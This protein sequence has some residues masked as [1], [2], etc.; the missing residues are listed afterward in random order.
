MKLL[1]VSKDYRNNIVDG[2]SIVI[3]RNLELLKEILGAANVDEFYIN[4][5]I[6]NIKKAIKMLTLSSVGYEK[7][8]LHRLITEIKKNQYDFIFV[9]NSLLGIYVKKIKK[10]FPQI[11][12][13]S[14]FH[15]IEL[16]YFKE[17]VKVDGLINVI[18][19]PYAYHN[20]KLTI[21]YSNLVIVLNNRDNKFLKSIYKKD[22]NLILPLTLK[23]KFNNKIIN[24]LQS[25]CNNDLTYIFVGSNF[26][27]NI[28]GITWFIENVSKNISGKLQ[29]IGSGMEILKEKYGHYQNIEILGFVDDLSYYYINADFVII[30]IFS[31]SGM[32]TKTTEALMYGKTIFGTTEAFEGFEL[33][34]DKVGALCNSK[35]EFI[36]SINDYIN[37]PR[38]K[39]NQYSRDIFLKKYSNS[40]VKQNLENLLINS[41]KWS[42]RFWNESNFVKCEKK[43][44]Y[45]EKRVVSWDI[46]F[47]YYIYLTKRMGANN[48]EKSL[49]IME[50]FNE[51]RDCCSWY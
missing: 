34:Y 24:N 48:V 41:L 15:N 50:G 29:I 32:K 40:A 33:D 12:I 20:E 42:V 45:S 49:L 30:P 31:G 8:V 38:S 6:L 25:N 4:T 35:E 16:N 19:L 14:F 39:F 47:D 7:K 37:G 51:N 46:R 1:F 26:F 21:K 43:K 10:E 44:R 18:A 22:A 36:K 9:D 23:D 2:G 13:V 28:E 3:K 5:K 17:K 11:K 27:A